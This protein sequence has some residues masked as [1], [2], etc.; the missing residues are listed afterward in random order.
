MT[1]VDTS[2]FPWSVGS[3]GHSVSESLRE[4]VVTTL[5]VLYFPMLFVLVVGAPFVLANQFD[6]R[7]D[8][9]IQSSFLLG[10]L[11]YLFGFRVLF[12]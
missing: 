11:G 6:L 2:I 1:R 8:V 9:A 10:A 12:R 4:A 7:L 5:L 3:L